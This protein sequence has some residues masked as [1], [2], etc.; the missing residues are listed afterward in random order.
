[1]TLGDLDYDFPTEDFSCFWE[2]FFSFNSISKVYKAI[3]II[4][5]I[6]IFPFF[7]VS[8]PTLF[9]ILSLFLLIYAVIHKLFELIH[10][11]LITFLV[12]VVFLLIYCTLHG[13]F[14]TA[15]AISVLPDYVVSGWQAQADPYGR[16]RRH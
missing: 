2:C 16:L 4:Y 8:L 14:S 7:I 6:I 10:L 1:M 5:S 12:D 15:G 9:V 11:H 3:K 13:F